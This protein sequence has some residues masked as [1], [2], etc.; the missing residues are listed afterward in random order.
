MPKFKVSVKV[1][2]FVFGD[3]TRDFT[4]DEPYDL[5]FQIFYDRELR[6][7]LDE[8]TRLVFVHTRSESKK[9]IHVNF[10]AVSEDDF[11]E[12]HV[13]NETAFERWLEEVEPGI[14][15]TID[16]EAARSPAP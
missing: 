10:L 6:P 5:I 8:K 3:T 12:P 4:S 11:T 14:M 9:I 2:D 13:L 15:Q 7:S 1:R 16:P